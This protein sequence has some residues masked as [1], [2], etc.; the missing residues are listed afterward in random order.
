[1]NIRNHFT[2]LLGLLAICA[3]VPTQASPFVV[4]G[5]DAARGGLESLAPGGNPTLASDIAAAFPG[6]TFQFSNTLTPA[7]LSSVNVVILGVATTDSS[8]ITPLSGSEQSALTSFVLG[9]GTALI[10]SDNSTFDPNAPAVNASVLTPF[11]VTATGT[12]DGFVSAPILNSTGPLTSPFTPVTEFDTLFPGWYS[13]T[14]GGLVLADLNSDPTT[15]AIDFF[16]PGAL[17]PA[18]GAVVLFSD[19]NAII[20][21]TA[22]LTTSNLNLILNAFALTGEGPTTV[23]E[24]G[25]LA[26][27]GTALAGFGLARRRRKVLTAGT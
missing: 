21:T 7:F 6:T 12:E 10:F 24:P 27:L 26:L 9:G 19:S 1:M 25:T 22:D 14:N 3:A 17:G 5:F 2:Y 8:A 20:Q 16:A 13:D 15:P 23:P 11:G 18:S 4:G